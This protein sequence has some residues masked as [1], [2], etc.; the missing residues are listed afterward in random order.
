MRRLSVLLAVLI[1]LALGTA[2]AD[3]DDASIT[4]TIANND[5]NW[6]NLQHPGSGSFEAGDEYLIYAQIYEPGVTDAT[7]QG[8]GV[9]AWIGYS[10]T[11]SDPSGGGWTWVEATYHGDSNNNDEYKIDLGS[12]LSVANTYYVASRFSLDGGSSHQYGGY[13]SGGGGFWD[14]ATNVNAVFTVTVNEAP[15]LAAIG[16]QELTEEVP[17]SI[18][19]SATDADDDTLTFSVSGGGSETVLASVSGDTL[20]LTP[21]TDYFTTTG[22]E[23]TVTVE[24]EHGATD[25]ETFTVT[26]TNVNDA[27]MLAAL[28][29]QDGTEGEELSFTVSAT[30]ADGDALSWSS[31]NLPDGANLTDNGDNSATFA[32]TPSYSQSGTYENITFIVD[33]GQGGRVAVNLQTG[34][35]S[36]RGSDR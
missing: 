3:T 2:L 5:I 17:A 23:I 28:S 27:P 22:V 24:D 34:N 12:E 26:V 13:N 33:D 7:G 11:D 25:S 4:I 30:D 36:R 20:T 6:C 19:L 18:I 16:D 10:T 21:A 31:Q 1:T 15:V 14:G 35:A 29:D 9:D 8:S 32:W